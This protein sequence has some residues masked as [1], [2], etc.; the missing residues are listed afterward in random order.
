MKSAKKWQK[1]YI[2]VVFIPLEIIRAIQA[3]AIKSAEDSK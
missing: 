3:D 1:E 2:R